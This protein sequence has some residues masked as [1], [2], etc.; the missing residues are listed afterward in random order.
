MA[1][2]SKTQRAKASAARQQRKAARE[3]EEEA[4]KEKEASALE[5]E[6]TSKKGALSR[7][8][9]KSSQKITSTS[10]VDSS[11]KAKNTE[12]KKAETKQPKRSNRVVQF[13]RDMRSELHRVTWPSRRDVLQWTGVVVVALLFFGIFVAFF[14]NVVITPLLYLISGLGA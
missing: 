2:K 1:K 7:S 5:E 14:D 4:L 8:S 6:D 12:V 11:A 13:F 10:T 3:Q 9:E